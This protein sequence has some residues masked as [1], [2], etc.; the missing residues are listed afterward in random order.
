MGGSQF[1]GSLLE[2]VTP[3]Q[4]LG[5]DFGLQRRGQERR[6]GVGKGQG[7][8]PFWYVEMGNSILHFRKAGGRQRDHWSWAGEKGK[9]GRFPCSP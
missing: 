7:Y 2:S 8:L 9:V 1:G 3:E 4:C 6:K 5:H